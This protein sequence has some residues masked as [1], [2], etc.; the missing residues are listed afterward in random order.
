MRRP[1]SITVFAIMFGF[2]ALIS[3]LLAFYATRMTDF[4]FKLPPQAAHTLVMRIEMIR[5]LGIA[6]AVS[7]M[8]LVVLG[9]SRAARGALGMRWILGAGTS[10]AFLHSIGMIALPG[11][12]SIAVITLSVIQL[13]IEGFAILILYG[14][15]AATWFERRSVY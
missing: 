11:E 7:L 13:G 15:D 2:S 6:F 8:L 14:E 4:G 9:K 5:L 10:A 1:P 12:S 3:L